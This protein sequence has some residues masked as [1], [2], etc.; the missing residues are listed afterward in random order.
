VYQDLIN[1]GDVAFVDTSS[2]CDFLM[3]YVEEAHAE[4]EWPISSGR[5]NRGR[6]PVRINQ[7]TTS[8]ERISVAKQFLNSYDIPIDD[9]GLQVACDS[10]EIGNPFEKAYA[11]WPLRLYVIENGKMTFIA[12][13]KD[14][15]Y[16]VSELREWL[17]H[18]CAIDD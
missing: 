4:N 15:T 12:Q 2:R 5:Y 10:P 11:P 8:N 13:P 1:G 18:R 17:I 7:P 9:N 6:G 14:C 16:D 3:M